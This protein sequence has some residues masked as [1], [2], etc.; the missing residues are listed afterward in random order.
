MRSI[1]YKSKY[2]R[3]VGRLALP[4]V[5]RACPPARVRGLIGSTFI[6]DVVLDLI[7]SGHGDK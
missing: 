2:N 3:R 1:P 6:L 5:G 7:P 4:P